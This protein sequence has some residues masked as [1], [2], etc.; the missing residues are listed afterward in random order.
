MIEFDVVVVGGGPAG[1]SAAIASARNG[2]R[3]ALFDEHPAVGGALRYRLDPVSLLNGR[4]LPGPAAARALVDDA[5][6][7]RVQIATGVVAWG[8][9]SG[10]VV[11][12]TGLEAHQ[13]I[14]AERLI[15]ATG[16]TD[17]AAAF[18]GSDLPGVLT[19]SA[20]LRL[21]HVHRVWP[22]GRR[23]AIVGAGDLAEDVAAA[24]RDAGGA[25]EA[26]GAIDSL[27]VSGDGVV[28]RV[29]IDGVEHAADVVAICA[30]QRPDIS[31]AL[32]L[33]ADAGY[34]SSLGGFTVLR[35][36]SLETSVAGLYVCG[37][38]GGI[39]SIASSLAEGTLAGLAAAASLGNISESTLQQEITAFS[40]AFP[41]RVQQIYVI[42][43]EWTQH[44]VES[45]IAGAGEKSR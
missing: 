26:R 30:G 15:L 39:G 43:P 45:V 32:A 11:G 38:A 29:E 20:L 6:R 33:E 3:T 4:T 34:S 22:G 36:E 14:R 17:L 21:L 2:L 13:E 18:S 25:V 42:E 44:F 35:S 41:D 12:V 8:A 5:L 9:F 19:G 10:F 28:E 40:G 24:V 37:S 27:T 1:L 7:Q 31:L 16:S 23:V